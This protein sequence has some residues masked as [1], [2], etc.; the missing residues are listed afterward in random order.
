MYIQCIC[1]AA[2]Y[3]WNIPGVY[4][5]YRISIFMYLCVIQ[6]CYQC[7]GWVQYNVEASASDKISIPLLW[8]SW[9]ANTSSRTI[10]VPSFIKVWT[11][12]DCLNYLQ[13]HP[14]H[15]NHSSCLMSQSPSALLNF[16][17]DQLFSILSLWLIL[18]TLQY[19]LNILQ[20]NILN[21]LV[22]AHGQHFNHHLHC[23]TAG[24]IRQYQLFVLSF[25]LLE[26]FATHHW[27]PNL[28]PKSFKCPCA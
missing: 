17:P 21:I 6:C 23:S 2:V 5:G 4:Y 12:Q 27:L 15:S 28:K 9:S 26:Y 25:S 20:P 14:Q 16:R 18:L 24:S 22:T 8:G 10:V 7:H 3:A 1:R 19:C 11:R 13:S